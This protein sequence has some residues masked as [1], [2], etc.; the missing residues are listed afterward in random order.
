MADAGAMERHQRI[1]TWSSKSDCCGRNR[2]YD[3]G[4]VADVAWH[5]ADPATLPGVISFALGK[6]PDME[7]FGS[8]LLEASV[9][10]L[11][12]QQQMVQIMT[13]CI[14][15][16][17]SHGFA[18]DDAPRNVAALLPMDE[19]HF[20]RACLTLVDFDNKDPGLGGEDSEDSDSDDEEN[21]EWYG[22]VCAVL[23]TV[24]VVLIGFSTEK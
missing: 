14:A 22:K 12:R 4:N 8:E 5:V 1:S 24:T 23:K 7:E 16:I 20:E 3:L 21:N 6:D 9:G 11:D 13:R 15:Q 2:W 10:K 17:A 19:D 18:S